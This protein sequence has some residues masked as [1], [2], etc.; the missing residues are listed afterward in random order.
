MECHHPVL[1]WEDRLISTPACVDS[2]GNMIFTYALA[3]TRV[4]TK[5]AHR[6]RESLNGRVPLNICRRGRVTSRC[7]S[8]PPTPSLVVAT[9][10]TAA[11]PLTKITKARAVPRSHGP[12]PT[13]GQRA[14]LG[15]K[16]HTFGHRPRTSTN[17]PPRSRLKRLPPA[18]PHLPPVPHP[19]GHLHTA[20][21]AA[22][23]Q[24]GG[25]SHATRRTP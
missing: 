22:T 24:D 6:D 1:G 23:R 20:A 14:R 3:N 15:T 5:H 4:N 13:M 2:I 11:F 25:G 18:P 9:H 8:G 16:C 10:D 7:T 19:V 17:T 21:N 12:S